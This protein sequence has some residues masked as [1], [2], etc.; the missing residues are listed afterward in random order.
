MSWKWPSQQAL[1]S[2]RHHR[3]A[4]QGQGSHNPD[5]VQVV[6]ED[7]RSVRASPSIIERD[8]DLLQS[9]ASRWATATTIA[10]EAVE[11]DRHRR[12]RA[13]SR[14][15]RAAPHF[16]SRIP[17]GAAAAATSPVTGLKMLIVPAG[18]AASGERE[19][20]RPIEPRRLA[21]RKPQPVAD[22]LG[23]SNG[24][25]ALR[26]NV[27]NDGRPARNIIADDGESH[28]QLQQREAA[29]ACFVAHVA[30][31]SV[32]CSLSSTF[33]S[34]V[35]ACV[36]RRFGAIVGPESPRRAEASHPTTIEAQDI[37]H[38]PRRNRAIGSSG[39]AARTKGGRTASARRELI[40]SAR[41]AC[42]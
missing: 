30:Q 25:P 19:A 13:R 32:S 17:T 36:P 33:V 29:R 27:V 10:P 18:I 7:T 31:A 6:D 3:A 28:H 22:R 11:R 41:A 9:S 2:R 12:C 16:E 1:A 20:H 14:P 42:A 34:C 5:A 15:S 37:C 4:A 38:C 8:V 24:S 21:A 23:R 39:R 40:G 26:R 35:G